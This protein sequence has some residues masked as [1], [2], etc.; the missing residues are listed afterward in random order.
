MLLYTIQQGFIALENETYFIE[1]YLLINSKSIRSILD[2]AIRMDQY[3][4]N[5]NNLGAHKLFKSVKYNFRNLMVRKKRIA[6]REKR[7]GLIK[8]RYI[9][10]FVIVDHLVFN[11]F[12]TNNRNLELYVLTLFSIV[13][14]IY[15]H[16]TIQT[17]LQI[18]V[19]N[20]TIIKDKR[21]Y[22]IYLYIVV[23]IK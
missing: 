21:V 23:V 14:K 13:N 2:T 5:V 9:E 11:E 20:I 12:R 1:P 7:S 19:K 6:G 18:V 22:T 17:Q 8:K 16:P 15:Q 3:L 4:P 10:T